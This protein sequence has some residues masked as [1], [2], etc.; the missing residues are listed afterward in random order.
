MR[1]R[2]YFSLKHILFAV[3]L[4]ALMVLF[5]IRQ[6]NTTVKV[7]F[8][9]ESVNVTSNKY[10]MTILYDD[11]ADAELITLAEP[12][13]RLADAYDDDILRAGVWRNDTWGDY[14]IV[15]DLD[16]DTCILLHLNDGRVLVFNRKDNTATAQ[17]YETLLTYLK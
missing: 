5:A 6:S 15:A 9:E 16:A 2:D 7:N 17:D 12:G 14:I 8:R 11:I 4:M 10:S 3:V 1:F 13:E